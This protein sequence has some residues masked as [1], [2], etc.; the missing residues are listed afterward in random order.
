MNIDT[1]FSAKEAMKRIIHRVVID[2]SVKI[3]LIDVL[4]ANEK[5]FPLK[6]ILRKIDSA[7]I[8]PLTNKEKS[9]LNDLTA[10]YI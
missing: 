2:E 5:T 4:Y 9:Q 10:L 3:N 6:A 8:H 1:M 7:Q